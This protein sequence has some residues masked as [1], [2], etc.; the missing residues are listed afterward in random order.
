LPSKNAYHAR[1]SHHLL[2]SVDDV[3][4]GELLRVGFHEVVEQ[5]FL[6]RDELFF[7]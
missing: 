7:L 2:E 6:A 3:D 5:L 4:L 1:L